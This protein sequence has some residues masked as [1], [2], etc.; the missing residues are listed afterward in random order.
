MAE[1]L[2]KNVALPPFSRYVLFNAEGGRLLDKALW[3]VLYKGIFRF[4]LL[5]DL[6]KYCHCSQDIPI[7]VLLPI[8]VRS[9]T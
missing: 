8:P 9:V 2:N 3:F 4:L 6:M 5:I 7:S 1:R